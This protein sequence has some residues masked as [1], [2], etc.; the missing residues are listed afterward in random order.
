MIC[1]TP[2]QIVYMGDS[3]TQGLGASTPDQRWSAIV[4]RN[5]HSQEINLGVSGSTLQRG[6]HSWSGLGLSWLIPNKPQQQ[7]ALLVIS[8]GYND[9]RYNSPKFN[10]T[11]YFSGL[12][13]MVEVA[14]QHG[15]QP[16]EI[17]ISSMPWQHPRDLQ[18]IPYPWDAS[19]PPKQD[20]YRFMTWL[21]AAV[22][23]TK[24]ADQF[25]ATV[26]QIYPDRVH[27]GDAGHQAIANAVTQAACQSLPTPLFATTIPHKIDENKYITYRY[28]AAP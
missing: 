15:Y 20:Y 11:S 26:G 22:S 17:I 2:T 12:L 28:P 24:F 3:I 14:K 23:G 19:T 25:G 7:Q 27:P 1:P 6:S 8:Y 9:I 18:V 16:E 21:A 4:T 10:L 13:Q 5:L